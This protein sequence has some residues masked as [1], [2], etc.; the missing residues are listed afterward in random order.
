MI[1]GFF[2]TLRHYPEIALF[3]ALGDAVFL[4]CKLYPSSPLF[5]DMHLLL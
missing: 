5:S 1:A 3:L 4:F 2:A